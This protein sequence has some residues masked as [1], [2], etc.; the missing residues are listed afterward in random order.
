[1][2]DEIENLLKETKTLVEENNKIL[3]GI[4]RSNRWGAFI[5]TVYWIIIIVITI[6]AFAYI[7]PY[8]NSMIKIYNQLEGTS[9]DITNLKNN[10]NSFTNGI[11]EYFLGT[12]TPVKK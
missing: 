9:T 6:G 10:Q 8:L 4:R 2:D 7:Q 1:M 12:S 3:K 11:K 5:K